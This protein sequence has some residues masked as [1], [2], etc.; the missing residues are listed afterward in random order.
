[1]SHSSP[2]GARVSMRRVPPRQSRRRETSLT[3]PMEILEILS[4][5]AEP[6]YRF[7]REGWD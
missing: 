1:V 6:T 5:T 7:L 4:E 3:T 2:R